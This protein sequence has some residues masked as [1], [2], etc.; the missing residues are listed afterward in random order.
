[1]VFRIISIVSLG[2]GSGAGNGNSG[3]LATAHRA[4]CRIELREKRQRMDFLDVAG[5]LVSKLGVNFRREQPGS[6]LKSC[7]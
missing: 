5:G 3:I 7:P 2:Y 1:M 6:R 4:D